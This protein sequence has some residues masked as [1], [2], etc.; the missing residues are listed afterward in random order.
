MTQEE[1]ER[2][3]VWAIVGVWLVATGVSAYGYALKRIAAPTATPGY[4][5]EWSFQLLMFAF[6]RGPLFLGVLA[7]VLWA[8]RRLLR[9]RL[10]G[11]T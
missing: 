10:A 1:R 5:T 7:L 2:R 11:G 3:W 9:R 4:E 8:Q 6:V